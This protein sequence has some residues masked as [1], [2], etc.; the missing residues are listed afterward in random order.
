MSRVRRV[1]V[2]ADF[3]DEKPHSI[4]LQHR[5]WVKGLLRLGLDVQRF[6]YRNVLMQLSPLA[7]KR[8]ALRV[9]KRKCDE[10]LVK[11]IANYRPDIVLILNMSYLDADTV[12]MAREAAPK[13]VFVGRDNDALPEKNP[14]RLAIAAETDIVVATSAGAFLKTYKAASVPVCA[15]LP[16]TCDPDIQY[17]Y[18]VDERWATDVL[19]TGKIEHPEHDPNAERSALLQRLHQMPNAK[20]YGSLGNPRIDGLDYFQAIS[21]ART[22]LSINLINDIRMYHSDRFINYI[23]CGTLTLARRVPD[24]ELLFQD[25]VHL[26]YFDEPGEFFEL[27]AYY[28]K[29]EGPRERIARAGMEH[30][31]QEFNCVRLAQILLDLIDK[32]TYKAP[33]AE[34]V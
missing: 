30:A 28:L 7:S 16:N 32:G 25:E 31:H 10:C 14:A 18:D 29:H 2:I 9:A 33:W 5:M 27:V 22:A 13:A 1:F 4:H 6:S 24:T 26:R 15:F 19:F 23:S 11:Q 21:G 3:R 17:H 12:R 34:V 8:F 20:I